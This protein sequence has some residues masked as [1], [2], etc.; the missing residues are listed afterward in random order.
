[1]RV[2]TGFFTTESNENYPELCRL[3]HYDLSFGDECVEKCKVK[4]VFDNYSIETIGSVYAN[5]AG[6]G[7]IEKESFLYIE[8]CFLDCIRTH[9]H[10]LDGL[11]LHLHGASYVEEIGS[12]DH[13]LLKEIRKITGPYFPIAVV[14]D[15]HGNLTQEYVESCTILR[16]Y[17]ES[18]HTDASQTKKK[19]AQL[20]CELLIQREHVHAV[21]RK[22]P[23][24]LGG[25][26]SVSTDEPVRTIN[27][28]MDEMESDSRILSASWHV[29]YLRHDCPEAGCGI[30]VVPRK[31]KDF[32]Y[33]CQKADELASFVWDKRHEFHY[34]GLTAEPEEALKLALRHEGRPV[35][36]TDSGDNTTSGAPGI[37]TYMLR[38]LLLLEH[39]E[40]H[41]LVANITDESAYKQL[42]EQQLGEPVSF[43]LGIDKDL[44]SKSVHLEG[45]IVSKGQMRGNMWSGREK[46]WGHVVSVRLHHLPI[47]VAIS[48]CN[49]SMTEL[50]QFEHAGLNVDDYDVI[51]VKQGYLFPQLKE[52]ASAS[53]MSLTDG[54]TPQ[55]TKKINF[56]R[57]LR[58][59]FP[60]DEI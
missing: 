47:T 5:A 53:I 56:K 20:L 18:P 4:K 45:T 12:G 33:A 7:V 39:L 29:G 14:C 10:E 6:A 38:Q 28:F 30:V 58:P 43:D 40:K 15:P 59:M 57:I 52:I 46:V 26:Q 54:A 32:A 49:N 17:R 55:N 36:L 42:A 19:V 16:S 1:M 24:I 44:H 35:F 48:T 50:A 34:T 3:N 11:W 13:H 21:Y 27:R 37:N 23:L 41:V 9:L 22:L 51:V 25:E 2:M 31:N 60:I 8:H